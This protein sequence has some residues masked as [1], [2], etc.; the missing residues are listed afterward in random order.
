MADVE[1]QADRSVHL[2]VKRVA[3]AAVDEHDLLV[4]IVLLDRSDEAVDDILNDRLEDQFSVRYFFGYGRHRHL[5]HVLRE[6]V[7][8]PKVPKGAGL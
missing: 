5:H 8:F 7:P 1:I 3:V 4:R 2:D 6:N